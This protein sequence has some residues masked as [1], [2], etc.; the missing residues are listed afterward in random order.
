[1]S[2]DQESFLETGIPYRLNNLEL[3]EF[4]AQIVLAST[5]TNHAHVVFT[6]GHEIQGAYGLVTN[7]MM[8][9]GLLTCRVLLDFLRSSQYN[10]DVTID[11]CTRT[12]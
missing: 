2:F 11:M 4:A 8:E 1:M 9:L 12:D 3:F 7:S 5:E 6:T 10:G